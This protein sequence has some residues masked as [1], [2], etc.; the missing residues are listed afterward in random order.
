MTTQKPKGPPA[1]VFD[2]STPAS[3]MVKGMLEH[4]KKAKTKPKKAPKK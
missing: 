3:T 2:P 1:L 4:M